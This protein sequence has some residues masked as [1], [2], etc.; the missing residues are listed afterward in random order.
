MNEEITP[1][2]GTRKAERLMRGRI[3]GLTWK[4]MLA[5]FAL[6]GLIVS[7]FGTPAGSAPIQKQGMVCT[8]GSYNAGTNTRTFNLATQDGYIYTPEGNTVYSWGFSKTGTAFQ[9]PGPVLCVNEGEIIRVN[10]NN[11]LAVPVSLLFP[12]QENVTSSGGSCTGPNDPDCLL[13][14]TGGAAQSTSAVPVASTVADTAAGN[15]DAGTHVYAL[16]EVSGGVE[17]DVGPTSTTAT[18][19]ATHT[20]NSISLPALPSGVDSY[21]LYRSKAGVTPASE[22]DWYQVATGLTPG[23]PD[24]VDGASDASLGT[25]PPAA[26][27]G[28]STPTVTTPADSSLGAVDA[29][30]HVYAFTAN[31][32]QGE[33][34]IGAASNIV[35]ND[36]THTSNSVTVPALAPGVTSY[37]IYRTF[38]GVTT[39]GNTDWH[40]VA[41]N[42]SPGA[43]S[44]VQ[45][46]AAL[47]GPPP[48]TTAWYS[49]VA[50]NPGTYLYQSGTR[51][52]LEVEMG[53]YGALV[54]RPSHVGTLGTCSS[55][56]VPSGPSYAYDATRTAFDPCRENLILMSEIDPD[57]HEQVD[58]LVNNSATPV[59]INPD[60]TNRHPRYWV[61]N[62][63]SFPDVIYANFVQWLPNQPYGGL[64]RVQP[65]D[66]TCNLATGVPNVPAGCAPAMIRYVNAG[67]DNHPFHPH[68]NDM[69]VIGRDARLLQ[70]PNGE[71]T[72]FKDFARVVG[73]GQTYDL[74]FRWLLNCNPLVP[75]Y[76]GQ[77]F[78][79]DSGTH[80]CDQAVGPIS[81]AVPVLPNYKNVEFKD[82]DVFYSGNAYLGYKGTLTLGVTTQ[83]VCGEY[84]F[85]WH[86]HALN[87]FVN[88]DALFGGLAT[89][90]RVDPPPGQNHAGTCK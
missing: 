8:N 65:Q 52:T 37:N 39:P 64:V 67:F 73:A 85:P 89:L 87:E 70:G 74:M 34:Q 15:V 12:G 60:F 80:V 5:V 20:T 61:V 84:Y 31:T 82:N 36:A 66:Q 3:K 59:A 42:Q 28:S 62:G 50:T 69:L 47:A 38:A 17:S 16:T 76:N 4:V 54:V 86:S 21:N 26:S 22:S 23:G 81:N 46:D 48:T 55:T 63:R 56:G 72:S 10:L 6:L 40:L 25:N 71:D 2:R 77:D 68:G 9:L 44:D 41:T 32:A 35:T 49:F 58:N 75:G 88:F 13:A 57:I 29:G 45:P 14:K 90:V 30:T 83:N 79:P 78:H 27:A 51:Q 43:Y 18:N 11:S 33:S 1:N 7:G 24:Y 53:L 19:D